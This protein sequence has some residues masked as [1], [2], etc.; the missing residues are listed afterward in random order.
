MNG[1]WVLK[2]NLQ[3]DREMFQPQ[4]LTTPLQL[5]RQ[6]ELAMTIEV[7]EHLPR[8]QARTFVETLCRLSDIVLFSAA[9]PNQGVEHVNEQ[10]PSFW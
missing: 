10:W 2:A 8:E 5:P 1:D 9:I 4:D 6:F 3:V 7:G